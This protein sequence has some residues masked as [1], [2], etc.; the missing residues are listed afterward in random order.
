MRL[1]IGH[2]LFLALFLATSAVVVISLLLTRWSFNQGFLDYVNAVEANRIAT[3]A[4]TLTDIY[5]E[6]NSWEPIQKNR[7]PWHAVMQKLTGG[8]HV[9]L[10]PPPV[11][12]EHDFKPPE[13]HNRPPRSPRPAL[14]PGAQPPELLDIDKN[15]I[16]GKPGSRPGSALTPIEL[17]GRVIGYLRYMPISALTDLNNDAERQF[18]KQQRTALSIT[19][20][21]ALLIALL[22]ALLFGRRLV[23]PIRLLAA[24]TKE[25]KAGHLSKPLKITSSDE[26]G[27][28]AESF[29]EMAVS[30][31]QAQQTQKKWVADIAHELRTPLAILNGELQA[32]EDGIREWNDASRES[33]QAELDRLRALVDDLREVSLADAGGLGYQ[34][35]EIDLRDVI[36]TALESHA[37]RIAECG[38][39]IQTDLPDNAIPFNGDARRLQQVLTNLLENSCRYT[40]SGGRIL[41]SCVA[42]HTVRLIVADSAPGAPAD[43]LPRLFDRL[44]RADQSRNRSHG[45][46]GLGLAICKGIIEAHGGSID[47]APSALGGLTVTVELPYK[48]PT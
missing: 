38:L 22:L 3:A 18:I 8:S 12:R 46:S 37:L 33:L 23:A 17:D 30:L 36:D 27:Q 29:N 26:L 16:I 4:S 19:A 44:F 32:I 11:G 20:A 43:A 47:A 41:L 39:E 28:L 5:S 35:R 21:V 13:R 45:G 40:D 24:G 10:P 48:M 2:K 42:G 6:Q 1:L 7:E 34:R 31:E 14:P 25:L 9:D 15:I